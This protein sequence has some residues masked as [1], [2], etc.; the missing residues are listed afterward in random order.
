MLVRPESGLTKT[1]SFSLQ[2]K[3]GH[4]THA[5]WAE[6]GSAYWAARHG[7]VVRPVVSSLAALNH[8]L[9][10]AREVSLNLSLSIPNIDDGCLFVITFGIIIIT[11]T[12]N[13]RRRNSPVMTEYLLMTTKNFAT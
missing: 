8:S 1:K 6:V 10:I 7:P 4:C 3:L 5:T 2:P 11:N 9:E 13:Q 12:D